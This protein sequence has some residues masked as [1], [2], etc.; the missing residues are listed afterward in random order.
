MKYIYDQSEAI[1]VGA[2]LDES[3]YH[4]GMV[5]YILIDKPDVL[6]LPVSKDHFYEQTTRTVRISPGHVCSRQE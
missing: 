6:D 3:V 5:R 4:L 1:R 2:Q